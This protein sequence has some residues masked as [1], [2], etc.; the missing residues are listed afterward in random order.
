MLDQFAEKIKSLLTTGHRHIPPKMRRYG[1]GNISLS[2]SLST[3]HAH[4]LDQG[5]ALS[6]HGR[7]KSAN[8]NSKS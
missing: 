6:L 2:L 7:D 4:G 5:F 1:V 8:W 3:G